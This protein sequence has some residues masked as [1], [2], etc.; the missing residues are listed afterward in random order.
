VFN[1]TV[2]VGF[3]IIRRRVLVGRVLVDG[4]TGAHADIA[5]I[6]VIADIPDG[7][8]GCGA[9]FVAHLGVNHVVEEGQ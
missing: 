2:P 5:D 1:R 8:V 7:F 3:L 6:P 9:V 4:S